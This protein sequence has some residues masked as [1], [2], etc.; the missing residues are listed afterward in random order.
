MRRATDRTATLT[1]VGRAEAGKL[2]S[3]DIR[4]SENTRYEESRYEEYDIF[5]WRV[6]RLEGD[7]TNGS[8]YLCEVLT[9]WSTN[10]RVKASCFAGVTASFR[11]CRSC[12]ANSCKPSPWSR[13]S[14]CPPPESESCG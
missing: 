13:V 6:M 1:R 7:R 9:Q 12:S 2:V 3:N 10:G 4:T 8:S 5:S 14:N 11:G